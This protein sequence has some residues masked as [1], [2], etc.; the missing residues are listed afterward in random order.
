MRSVDKK[1]VHIS[2][3]E[4]RKDSDGKWI[5]SYTETTPEAYICSHTRSAVVW[6]H[7]LERCEVGGK[8]QIKYPSYEG[9]T[10]QFE[11]YQSFAS[12]AT[13][14]FGYSHKDSNGKYWQLDKDL[15]TRGNKTYSE[16]TCLFVPHR[17]NCLL[18]TRAGFRG[19]YPLG[20]YFEQ[21]VGKFRANCQQQTKVPKFLGYFEDPYQAHKEWQ[22]E[23]YKQILN[24]SLQS[25][26]GEKLQ[27]ALLQAANRV[28]WDYTNGVCTEQI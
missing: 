24:A 16:G 21:K 12:W 14:E 7:M 8:V 11:G 5:M 4:D 10:H 19:E 18:T 23:K 6:R 13:E 27:D 25:S 1:K 17:V 3:V 26:L 15:L 9:T 22:L 2:G 28:M 20:V